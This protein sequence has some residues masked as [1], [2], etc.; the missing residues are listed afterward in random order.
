M[1]RLL[2]GSALGALAVTVLTILPAQP[3]SATTSIPKA[4]NGQRVELTATMMLNRLKV[5]TEN[6]IGYE[7]TKFKLWDD[8][9]RDCQNTRAEVLKAE[10]RLAT[11]S[12]CSI[13]TGSWHSAYDGKIYHYASY[14]DIDHVVPLAEAWDSGARSWGAGRR[15]AYANDLTDARTLLAVSASS[16]RSKGDRDPKDWLPSQGLCTYIK[17]WIAVKMRWTL[18]VN[19]GEK[20]V[21]YDWVHNKCASSVIVV[22][23]AEVKYV[24]YGSTSSGGSTGGGGGGSTGGTTDP[25]FGTCTEAKSHGY[26]PYYEGVDP[27]YYWYDDRDNDGIVCE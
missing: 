12:G 13:S 4:V 27:E 25:R 18:S 11:N 16:N 2:T 17:N 14:I 6:R 22:H 8:V 21:L 5:A 1:K 3:A 19:P 20:A 10:S 24:V 23:K 7:R 9:D 15:E 26:G